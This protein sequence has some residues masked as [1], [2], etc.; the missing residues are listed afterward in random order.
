MPYSEEDARR[1]V[2]NRIGSKVKA[3]KDIGFES[4]YSLKE[5]LIKLIEWRELKL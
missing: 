4:A 2:Q 3:Q 1:L 5:G